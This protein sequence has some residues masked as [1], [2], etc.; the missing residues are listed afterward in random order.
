MKE[1]RGRKPERAASLEEPSPAT[2]AA[3]KIETTCALCIATTLST[4]ERHNYLRLLVP[5]ATHVILTHRLKKSCGCTQKPLWPRGRNVC[6]GC[7][8]GKVLPSLC[9]TRRCHSHQLKIKRNHGSVI[10][11]ATNLKT[12]E[13]IEV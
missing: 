9:L 2:T 8:C 5:F 6:V 11:T 1:V 4:Y 7:Y 3:F 10:W 12:K 13:Y